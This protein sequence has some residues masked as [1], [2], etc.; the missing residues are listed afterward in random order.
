M[1]YFS[2]FAKRIGLNISLLLLCFVCIFSLNTNA[3]TWE[4]FYN[5]TEF[6]YLKSALP[7]ADGG[8]LYIGHSLTKTGVP[9]AIGVVLMAKT[10]RD[11]QLLWQTTYTQG[12]FEEIFDAIPTSDGNYL[13]GGLTFNTAGN[14]NAD[15]WIIKMDP[16]GNVLWDRKY[17]GPQFDK[18]YGLEETSDG[19]FVFVGSTRSEVGGDITEPEINPDSLDAKDSWIGKIDV[20]GDL[21]WNHRFGSYEDDVLRDL[22]IADNG[23]ILAIGNY[24][25]EGIGGDWQISLYRYD[26][27]GNPIWDELYGGNGYEEAFSIIRTSDNNFAIGGMTNSQGAGSADTYLLRVGQIGEILDEDVYG[28]AEGEFAAFI[29]EMPDGG[30]SILSSTESFGSPFLDLYLIRTEPN[31]D[32]RWSRVFDGGN[33]HFDVPY[34]FTICLLYT[35]PSP[36]DLSTSRMP[37]SA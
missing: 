26:Q 5:F 13:L 22:A 6:D 16:E 34:P 30:F 23:D 15:G 14:G 29:Q 24:L 9:S 19:G 7:T 37:S 27:D 36:R 18:I 20:D 21:L 32:E 25:E 8:I 4:R 33:D 10:D 28:G 1:T 11:G 3:Q 17:G 2:T 31:G 35:S 12:F